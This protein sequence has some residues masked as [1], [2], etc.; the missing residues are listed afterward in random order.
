MPDHDTGCLFIDEGPDRITDLEEFEETLASLVT[1]M[2]ALRASLAEVEGLVPDV[3]GRESEL[4]EN[5]LVG[6]IGGLALGA[7]FSH[8]PLGQHPLERGGKHERFHSHV[9]ESGDDTR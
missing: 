9:D 6:F 1:G 7:D 3:V 4:R 8:E 2:V 5:G